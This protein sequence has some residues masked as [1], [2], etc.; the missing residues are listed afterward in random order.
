[1]KPQDDRNE[2]LLDTMIAEHEREQA[3]ERSQFRVSVVFAVA[4][5]AI[6]TYVVLAFFA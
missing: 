5:L 1:M 3:A 6:Y 2:N 4:F